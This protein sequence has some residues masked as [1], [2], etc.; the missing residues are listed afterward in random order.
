MFFLHDIQFC[1]QRTIYSHFPFNL[2]MSWQ[3]P[4]ICMHCNII[5]HFTHIAHYSNVPLHSTDF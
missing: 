3:I 2:K 1:F 5:H 4:K